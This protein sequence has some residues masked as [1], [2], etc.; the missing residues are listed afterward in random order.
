M[1]QVEVN[2]FNVGAACLQ[3]GYAPLGY[4]VTSI[5]I[6]VLQLVEPGRDVLYWV[7]WNGGALANIE[8]MQIH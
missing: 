5:Q 8:N 6:D 7:I 4:I 3:V 1:P 2:S